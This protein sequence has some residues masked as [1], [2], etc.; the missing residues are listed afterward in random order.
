VAP[1]P[2]SLPYDPFKYYQDGAAPA[3][4]TDMPAE[5]LS[6]L[7]PLT[8]QT[9]S[10]PIVANLSTAY[11]DSQG[12]LVLTGPVT[13]RPWEWVENLGDPSQDLDGPESQRDWLKHKAGLKNSGSLSLETFGAQSTGD[14]IVYNVANGDL[15]RLHDLRAFEDGL[16]SESVFARDFRETRI[17]VD[18]E[19]DKMHPQHATTDDASSTTSSS[20]HSSF[21]RQETMSRGSPASSVVSRSSARASTSS[22]KQQQSPSRLS[23]ATMSDI[24][25]YD[26]PS[27]SRPTGGPKRKLDEDD[28]DEI[29]ILEGPVRPTRARAGKTTAQT[30]AAGKTRG[31]ARKR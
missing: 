15:E 20:L 21:T 25:E 17:Q 16:S 18:P 7:L 4:P 26:M 5:Y 29:Q 28:D 22:R 27:T 14:S 12:G 30:T 10:A 24:M 19:D 1:D 6:Q 2:R 3:L 31:S 11:H 8:R 9:P 13:D 23:T